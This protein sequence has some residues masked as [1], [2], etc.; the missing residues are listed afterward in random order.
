MHAGES[1]F[2]LAF[3]AV[4]NDALHAGK[5]NIAITGA[6]GW[7]G[8]ALLEMLT[9]TFSDDFSARVAAFGSRE[10]MMVLR[11]G[12][13]IPLQPT[14]RMAELKP[15]NWLLVHAAYGTRDRVEMQGNMTFIAANETLTATV[16]QVIHALRPSA[17]LFPSSGAVYAPDGSIS[18]DLNS[19][20]YGVLKYRDELHFTSVAQT[21][22]A[23]IIIPRLF[24]MS[25]PYIN[26]WNAYALSDFIV[27]VLD[28]KPIT[29]NAPGAVLRSYIS[30]ADLLTL[31]FAWLLDDANNAASITF[32]TR[33]SEDVEMAD[34]ARMI[35]VAV[36]GNQ[37][38]PLRTPNAAIPANRYLGNTSPLQSLCERYNV[39]REGIVQQILNTVYYIRSQRAA[40]A[41]NDR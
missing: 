20:P 29:I 28:G 11:N 7:M 27:Q 31:S 37:T 26:K 23:R 39:S 19:N 2:P 15:A 35:E 41:L 3:P 1:F 36:L 25:G 16:T 32:D 6:S 21:V 10:Q 14:A 5:W 40:F 9:A 38:S 30:V 4:I 8:R 33:G 13:Q 22:G 24:N 18:T 34:L 12:R 17:I